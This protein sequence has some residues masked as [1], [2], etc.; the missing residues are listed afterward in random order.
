[1]AKG[2]FRAASTASKMFYDMAARRAGEREAQQTDW[3]SIH[4]INKNGQKG[5]SVVTRVPA[6]QVQAEI[7]RLE[8][9]NPGVKFTA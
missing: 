7:E 6:E 9:L 8:K 1:M 5:K 4:R 2:N 3:V